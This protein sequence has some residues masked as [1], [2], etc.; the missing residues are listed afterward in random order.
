MARLLLV[1][2][3]PD[4]LE[5]RRLLLEQA[6]HEVAAAASVADAISLFLSHT[7]EI[8]VMDLRL[9]HTRDGLALIRRLRS[10]SPAT[11]IMVLSGWS[12]DLANLPEEQMVDQVLTKPVRSQQLVQ[13]IAKLALCLIA[14]LPLRAA[15]AGNEFPFQ[16]DAPAEVVAD[17]DLSAPD[18]DWGRPGRESALALITVDGAGTQ[19]LMVYGGGQRHHY[20]V[21]LGP[22]EP[23]AHT[24]KVER[25]PEYS[26]RGIHLEVHN[27][28]Y[29]QYKPTD[30]GYAVIAN[31]PVLF[32]RRN[33]IGKFTDVPMILYCERLGDASLRYTMIFSNEDGGTSTRALMARWGRT[34]DI[35][36]I[37][38]VWPGKTGKPLKAQLQT[39]NH[40]D[41]EFRGK[42]E[43]FHPLLG[44]VTDNN[45]VAD[46]AASPIRY[47]LAPVIVDL[48]NASREKVMD[49][50]PITYLISARELEREGK[51]RT[52]GTAEGTKISAPE[53]Y[54]FV[55]MRVLNKDARVAVLVRL[56][57][58]NFFRSSNR[59][60]YDMGIERSGW[61]RTAIELPPATQPAQIAQIA[62]QCLP[63]AKSEGAG[64]CRVDAIGKMFFLNSRQIPDPSFYR[65]GMDRGPWVIPAG[66]LRVLSL[67]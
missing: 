37:Y 8:A 17:L 3:D 18:A 65:P 21:F 14:L 30:A 4:Q 49:E 12:A 59:G 66:D 19:H 45:M 15:T 5:L 54:L 58:D 60:V 6:G 41:V 29:R 46:D 55:E 35:E 16:L 22:L 38:E 62:F 11:R 61:V 39:N 2:D 31:A 64:S 1:D 44:V 10:E 57:E 51:L 52:F 23:G 40:K 50:H 20:Q 24:V 25:H 27:V 53:N 34:T 36:Y 28:T 32:A 48:T 13:F 56:Q 7:P 43:G 33:T 42:R 67:R 26:A 47:Q 9:P 63:E